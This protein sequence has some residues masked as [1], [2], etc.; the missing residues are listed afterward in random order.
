MNKKILV[1]AFVAAPL[2]LFFVMMGLAAIMAAIYTPDIRIIAAVAG[3]IS[4]VCAAMII[5]SFLKFVQLMEIK[6]LKTRPIVRVWTHDGNTVVTS[7]KVYSLSLGLMEQYTVAKPWVK[8]TFRVRPRL[9][10]IHGEKYSGCEWLKSEQLKAIFDSCS[11]QRTEMQVLPCIDT[12]YFLT[13]DEMWRLLHGSDYKLP[14][15][16]KPTN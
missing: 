16:P 14:E 4:M 8:R 1:M 10:A 3:V 15:F 12:E 5:L 11:V 7:D 6:S 2:A 9:F 13:F